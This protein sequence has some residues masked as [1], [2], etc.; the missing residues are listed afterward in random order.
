MFC[1]SDQSRMAVCKGR[2]RLT[3]ALIQVIV[4]LSGWR[5]FQQTGHSRGRAQLVA[6]RGRPI[7]SEG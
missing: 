7:R 4:K 6:L 3:S 5:W 1:D 2:K